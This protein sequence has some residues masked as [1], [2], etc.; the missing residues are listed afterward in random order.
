[1]LEK[2]V[3]R[4]RQVQFFAE[5]RDAYAKLAAQPA[6]W[7]DELAERAEFEGTL[8]DGLDDL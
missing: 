5:L 7:N 2:A 3:E 1:V 8:E 4:Y 6:A